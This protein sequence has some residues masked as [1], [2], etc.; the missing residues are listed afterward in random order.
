MAINKSPLK[1]AID[2]FKR[3]ETS[4]E[5]KINLRTLSKFRPTSL[6]RS[7]NTAI[8]EDDDSPFKSMYNQA[9]GG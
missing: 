6:Q 4:K 8:Q 1:S 7:V 3:P 9:Y 5:V 2:F